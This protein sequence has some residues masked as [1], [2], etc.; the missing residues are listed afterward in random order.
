MLVNKA[1]FA[2]ITSYTDSGVQV[3]YPLNP[4]KV[5]DDAS[6]EKF[7]GKPGKR[8]LLSKQLL[9]ATDLGIGAAKPPRLGLSRNMLAVGRISRRDWTEAITLKN[10][11]DRL[12]EI[13]GIKPSCTCIAASVDRR[14]LQPGEY[15]V[16]SASK[17]ISRASG[18]FGTTSL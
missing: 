13:T 5:V 4:P 16:L 14:Q 17:G 10:D 18:P 2:A 3:V 7:Y 11:G 9:S 6:F 1:G 12:I 8:A 15:A